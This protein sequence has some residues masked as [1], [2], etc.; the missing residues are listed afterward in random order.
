[1]ARYKSDLEGPTA[2]YRAFSDCGCLLYVGITRNP[3]GR[4]AKHGCTKAWWRTSVTSITY[5]WFDTRAAAYHA[6][7]V[8]I[9]EEAPVHNIARPRVV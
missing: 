6:E 9:Q 2:L 4:M 7:A 3:L 5:E 1:M 8:A